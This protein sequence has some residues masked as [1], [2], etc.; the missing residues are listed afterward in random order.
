MHLARPG[1]SEYSVPYAGLTVANKKSHPGAVSVTEDVYNPA[2][3]FPFERA[4]GQP[5]HRYEGAL[6]RLDPFV[7]AV[8]R[9]LLTRLPKAYRLFPSGTRDL[10]GQGLEPP[11]ATSGITDS[12][13]RFFFEQG[14]GKSSS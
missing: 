5:R 2:R 11:F 4:D 7:F 12:P 1:R 14:L 3:V 9:N 10:L 8:L 6:L 13:D